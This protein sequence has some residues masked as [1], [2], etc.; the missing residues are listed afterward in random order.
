MPAFYYNESIENAP[1]AKNCDFIRGETYMAKFILATDSG[2]DLS[3][4]YCEQH[5][6]PVLLMH[7]TMDGKNCTDTMRAEDQK[8]F[9]QMM[10]Q[11]SVAR[12]S[13]ANV[14]DYLEFWE[15]LLERGL[16]IVHLTLGSGIS[17]T[18]Q[19]ACLAHE[20]FLTMHPE[21]MIS[22]V[23]SLGASL[24]YGKMVIEAAQL[25]DAGQTA[26]ECVAWLEAHKHNITPY[27]TTG[28]LEY[29]Y[30][31]GRVSRAGMVIARALNIWP[32][33]NLNDLGELKVIDKC[34]GKK[35]NYEKIMNYIAEDVIDPQDQT[36]YVS[37]AAAFEEAKAFAEQ[38]RD[39]IGFRDIFYSQIGATIG[40][41]TGPGLVSLFYSGHP[42]KP[43]K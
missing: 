42:R 19:N 7:Y 37:H 27:F 23:D 24:V 40:A 21:A 20:Q 33:L 17:G 35:R 12:T 30:R 25:R 2:C 31:G 43:S 9:Y 18:Y 5:D 16:P 29:L 3:A 41:H 4:E 34:R 14:S 1:G 26:E 39:A 6:I 10:E 15:P 32:I 38:V 8:A 28:T 36:L 11:G 22:V 13:A